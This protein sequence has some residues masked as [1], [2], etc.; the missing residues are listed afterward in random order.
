KSKK[1]ITL[2]TERC[3]ADGRYI[4]I[5]GAS[6]N[7]LK[8]VNV[9]I[10][11]GMFIAV[12]GVSGSGKST[13]IN[14]ILQKAL[15]HHL[16]R[17]KAKPGKHKEIKGIDHLEKV[18]DIDQSPI[19]RTPR[20]NPATYIGVFDDIRD[21]YSNTNDAKVRGYKKGRFS[22]NVK[23]GRCEAC[24]GDG[25]IV[26]EMHFLPHAYVSCEVCNGKRFNRDK[27]EVTHKGQN[28]SE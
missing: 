9:K 10:P 20:S 14:E 15:A 19:G 12:T 24:S 17:A 7:N 4:E 28:I 18:I 23:G 3:K 11:L 22:D 1:F 16:N 13:L 2:T 21:V 25:I 26:I 8:N 5:K 6:E 27:L